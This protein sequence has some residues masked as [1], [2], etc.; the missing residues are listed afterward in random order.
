MNC[1]PGVAVV[2][3]VTWVLIGVRVPIVSALQ[4]EPLWTRAR[5]D[6]GSVP[7]SRSDEAKWNVAV[8]VAPAP[9]VGASD[10]ERFTECAGSSVELAMSA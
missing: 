7:A 5:N 10:H 9:F 8:H 4:L 2:S 1:V 3:P 6:A